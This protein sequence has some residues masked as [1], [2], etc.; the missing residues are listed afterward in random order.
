MT[1]IHKKKKKQS[2]II[3]VTVIS[4]ILI[5]VILALLILTSKNDKK[6][7]EVFTQNDSE[8][9]LETLSTEQMEQ[10]EE[11]TEYMGKAK[12]YYIDY[13]M[14]GDAQET[15]KFLDIRIRFPNG[16][17]YI[18]LTGKN[19]TY[20]TENGFYMYLDEKEVHMLSS[21]RTDVEVYGGAMLYL[22]SYN[23]EQEDEAGYPINLFVLS[24]YE[25]YFQNREEI[26]NRRIQ[27]EENLLTFM[28]QTL[29]K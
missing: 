11:T 17:D 7:K 4:V 21:A 5:I 25:E 27:L 9:T 26:Y 1:L 28:N 29:Q 2:I 13:V 8:E 23:R 3:I 14:V 15:D 20:I 6:E 12:E 16:E 18:V 19:I 10:T 22:S 24:S